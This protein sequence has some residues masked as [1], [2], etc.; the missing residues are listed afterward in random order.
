MEKC[1][2]QHK[3]KQQFYLLE[4]VVSMDALVSQ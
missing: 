1:N 3:K 2:L 4:L